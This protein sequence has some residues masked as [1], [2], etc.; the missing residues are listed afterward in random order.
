LLL[1]KEHLEM[2]ISLYDRERHRPLA[3]R[4]GL[5]AG[6]NCLSY[7]AWTLWHLGYP[8]QALKRGNEALAL[9]QGLSHPFSLA[10]AE[11]WVGVVRQFRGEVHAAKETAE[12]LIALSAERGF[13]NV[14]SFATGLRGWAIAKQGRNEDGIALIQEGLTASRAIRAELVRPYFL[15][16][17]AEA[18]RETGR[19]DD[20][21]SV[22]TEALAAADEHE[23]R[24]YEAEMHRLK[25]ELLLRQDQ[26]NAPEAQRCFE[27]AIEIAR[28]QSAKSWELR[29][30]ISLARLLR[31]TGRRD[32]ARTMLA[33]IYGWFT[34]GFD[35]ADL[36]DAKALLDQ[37]SE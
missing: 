27:R 6:V 25:G 9:A 34:E 15:C 32:K 21:L 16:L 20:G 37:L 12:S 30:T 2:A 29:A 22:L 26:S 35:T 10:F 13:P 28:N 8:E 7:A 11:I 14:L 18:C 4:Y 36:K 23:N 17:L 19:L 5:D 33:D 24:S 31:D 1:A 3:L